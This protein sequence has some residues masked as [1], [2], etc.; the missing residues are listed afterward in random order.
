MPVFEHSSVI[1][2]PVER[3]FAFHE[4]PAALERLTP[5]WP[6]VRVLSREGGIREGAR[7]VLELALGPLRQRWVAL[8]TGYEKD[9]LFIDRQVEGPF[10]SWLHHHRFEAA[11]PGLTRLTD[12]VEFSLPG[13]PPA[14]LLGAWF[15]RLQL[16]RMFTYRHAMTRRY[17][18]APSTEPV[19]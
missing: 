13:G 11:G 16:R 12:H 19:A 14:D 18:E 8:H 1:H 9:R 6:P 7:V 10:R 3:V 17:C 4:H 2:A 15:A 5:P